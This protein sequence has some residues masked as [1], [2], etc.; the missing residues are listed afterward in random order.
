MLSALMRMINSACAF[1]AGRNQHFTTLTNLSFTRSS[2]SECLLNVQAITSHMLTPQETMSMHR[3]CAM[4]ENDSR[5]T[6]YNRGGRAIRSR[7]ASLPNNRVQFEKPSEGLRSMSVG[8]RGVPCNTAVHRKRCAWHAS[9]FVGPMQQ[10]IKGILTL[11]SS[12]IG[13]SVGEKASSA[14][15]KTILTM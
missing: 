5:H 8:L 10:H 9:L 2:R 7:Y 1:A 3:F 14:G 11:L 15:S 13:M 12:Q 4:R 6:L